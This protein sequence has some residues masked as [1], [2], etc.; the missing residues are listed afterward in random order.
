MRGFRRISELGNGPAIAFDGHLPRVEEGVKPPVF[1][2]IDGSKETNYPS[3][4][5]SNSLFPRE[6]S[7][8]LHIIRRNLTGIDSYIRI[9]FPGFLPN[10][11]I[12]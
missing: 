3:F 2:L 8:S 7:Q 11:I 6:V 1:D 4:S 10:L 9:S 5:P 12:T